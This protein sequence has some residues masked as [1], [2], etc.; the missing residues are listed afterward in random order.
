MTHPLSKGQAG[1][2]CPSG[3]RVRD[4]PPSG[5]RRWGS[6]GWSGLCSGTLTGSEGPVLQLTQGKQGR[7]P[8]LPH[9][10]SLLLA[11][12]MLAEEAVHWLWRVLGLCTWH[13]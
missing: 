3:D 6:H 11:L 12:Q 4:L 1:Q 7:S 10:R 2:R 13:S 8:G 9:P 5:V